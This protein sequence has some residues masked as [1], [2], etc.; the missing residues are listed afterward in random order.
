MLQCRSISE[1]VARESATQKDNR[2]SAPIAF[3]RFEP[4]D[5]QRRPLAQR[6]PRPIVGSLEIENGRKI[7]RLEQLDGP[8]EQGCLRSNGNAWPE[9]VTSATDQSGLARILPV[10][11]ER[12][13]HARLALRSFQKAVLKSRSYQGFPIDARL[14]MGNT[15]SRYFG[16]YQFRSNVESRLANAAHTRSIERATRQS[17][18]S[19]SRKPSFR[20]ILSNNYSLEVM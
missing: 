1:N 9:E 3:H 12:S 11:S 5:H 15:D 20:W 8:Q 19:D 2:R 17:R 14:M 16:G 7:A 4:T 13:V 10:A 18:T 6:N